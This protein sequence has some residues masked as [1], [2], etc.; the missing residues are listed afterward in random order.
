MSLP[1]PKRVVKKSSQTELN[2]LGLI[3]ANPAISRIELSKLSGL[4]NAAITGVIVG[5]VN[6]GFLDEERSAVKA[7]GRKR[8]SLS[9]RPSLGSVVGVDLGTFNLRIVVTDLNG[10]VLGSRQEKS[11]MWRGRDAV[12]ARC[13]ALVRETVKTAGVPVESIRGI[14]VAFS[15]VIDVSMV[16][17]SRTHVSD[18]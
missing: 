10:D 2:V 15:G 11:E 5:L 6:K 12:L 8:V 16:A 3:Q 9:L 13:F 18:M 4:S 1:K 7:I 17:S 14:G